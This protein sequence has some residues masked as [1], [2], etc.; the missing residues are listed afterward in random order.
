MP[1]KQGDIVQYKYQ[2]GPNPMDG[3]IGVLVG[4]SSSISWSVRIISAPRNVWSARW[5]SEPFWD[6][7]NL[8]KITEM[9]GDS[10]P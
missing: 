6:E 7:P 2:G 5:W 1:F 8:I 4:K 3:A 10:S 9:S